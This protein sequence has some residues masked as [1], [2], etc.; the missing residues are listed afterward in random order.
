MYVVQ[1]LAVSPALARDRGRAALQ[2]GDYDEAARSFEIVLETQPEN[3]NVQYMMGLALYYLDRWDEAAA[4]LQ[5]SLAIR[6]ENAP[7]HSLLV[8]IY[9]RRQ[10]SE[11]ALEHG[12]RAVELDPEDPLHFGR[13][14]MALVQARRFEGALQAFERGEERGLLRANMYHTWGNLH[15]QKGEAAEAMNR[16]K[17]ALEISDRNPDLFFHMGLAWEQL[18]NVEAALAQYERA[19]ALRASH[20]AAKRLRDLGAA[21]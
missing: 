20:P 18:G 13:M 2:R 12:R 5:A 8:D 21:R 10:E 16:Y 1:Q 19:I 14:G 17:Q 4:H 6:E 3:A 11:L 15:L 7:A 9:G